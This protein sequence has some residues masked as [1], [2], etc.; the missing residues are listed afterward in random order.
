MAIRSRPVRGRRPGNRAK[1]LQRDIME[2]MICQRVYL[3]WTFAFIASCMR[4]F[5]SAVCERT[6]RNTFKRW[7][8]TGTVEH[9]PRRLRKRKMST[10]LTIYLVRLASARPWMYLDEIAGEVNRVSRTRPDLDGKTYSPSV[11]PR[12]AARLRLDLEENARQGSR[13]RRVQPVEVLAGGWRR[14]HRRSSAY[15]CG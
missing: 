11:L 12:S 10:W 1:P 8:T 9:A 14:V 7:L 13:A 2:A 6:V 5:C 4:T 3:G 15:I